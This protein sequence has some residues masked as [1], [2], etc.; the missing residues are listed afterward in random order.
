MPNRV[1]TLRSSTAG[2]LPP[3]GTR[4]P[5]ELWLNFA[6]YALGFIDASQTAQKLLAVRWFVPTTSYVVGDFV[7]YSGALYR[8]V[9]PSP[10]GGFVAANWSKVGTAAD[11][12]A[13]QAYVDAA[14]A[15][16]V[17]LA[18]GTMS[19]PLILNADPT[20]ALGATTKQYVDLHSGA[21]T[22]SATP[23]AS[24]NPGA[25]WWDS[26]GGQLYVWYS[27]ANTSQWVVA[28]NGGPT[29]STSLPHMDG[30][31]AIGT[32][33]TWARAD[34]VHPTD[35]SLYPA[36]NPSGFQTAAQVTASLG[37]Y[38][39]LTGGT[40]SGAFSAPGI[41]TT[42]GLSINA[43]SGVE[44]F[45]RGTTNGV[46]RWVMDLGTTAAESGSNVGSD[47][48]LAR[49]NDGGTYLDSP[50]TIYRSSGIILMGGTRTGVSPG[51]GDGCSWGGNGGNGFSIVNS[52]A[53]GQ[54][55]TVN[56]TA[57]N[58]NCAVW[59]QNNAVCGSVS[60]A[61][62]NSCAYNTTS[63]GRLKEDRKPLDAGPILD[64]LEPVSFKWK[65]TDVR[66]V[67][68]IAQ[69]AIKVF[70]DAIT[71]IE[72]EDAWGADYSKFVPLLLAEI[73]SLRQRV[74]QL[75]SAR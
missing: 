44:R 56:R 3:T 15:L 18:G 7:L 57:A 25:L 64:A 26:V 11:L 74:A 36:S 8:A 60:V 66:G 70:P 35:T 17:P 37:N 47:F 34:H 1:Q 2:Q 16:R 27:D 51:N 58:G 71:Y 33:S 54:P 69:D 4:Q 59:Y 28:V 42:A 6:D 49:F 62:N 23:P 52:L 24:P 63:D 68:V 5:G 14:D 13:M 20:A 46:N 45:V 67:G 32:A 38:L 55:L 12:T 43:A 48:L 41:T 40:L 73:K 30:T 21:V 29:G 53:A 9:A 10:A 19:G 50:L 65:G 61:N 75:E 39:P 22:V 31:A 72:H